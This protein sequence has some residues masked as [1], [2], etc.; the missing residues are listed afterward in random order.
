MYKQ[1][2]IAR[3]DLSMSSGKLATQVSH[4]SMAFLTWMIRSNVKKIINEEKG[5]AWEYTDKPQ[6]YR[7]PDLNEFAEITRQNGK[8][9]FYY[10]PLNPNNPYGAQVMCEH[11]TVKEYFTE[12]S[13]AYNIPHL[14]SYLLNDI[15]YTENIHSKLPNF[16]D[17]KYPRN[18]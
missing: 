12:F 15:Y 9:L 6:Y 14:F 8:R 10:K 18:L 7:H 1:I 13:I 11:P 5:R 17:Y 3:K 2:I 4:G 16:Y